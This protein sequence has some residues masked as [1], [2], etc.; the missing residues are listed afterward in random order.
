MRIERHTLVW[1]APHR[2]CDVA[3]LD[4]R[5]QAVLQQWLAAGR[6]LIACRRDSLCDEVALGFPLPPAQGKRRIAVKAPLH[7]VA[8]VSPPPLLADVLRSMPPHWRAGLTPLLRDAQT[9]EHWR[10]ERLVRPPR[11]RQPKH[12]AA[13]LLPMPRLRQVQ[14]GIAREPQAF[15]LED[16]NDAVLLLCELRRC[17]HGRAVCRPGVT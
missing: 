14:D 10:K 6:P 11:A 2:Y 8:R 1:I 17:F 15:E 3:A 4:G 9:L 16:G 12:A 5:E 13:H 7:A